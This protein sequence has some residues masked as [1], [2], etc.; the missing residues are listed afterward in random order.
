MS[1]KQRTFN[2]YLVWRRSMTERGVSGWTVTSYSLKARTDKQAQ[3]R[4]AKMF[5]SAGFHSMSLVAVIDGKNPNSI[6]Q[7]TNEN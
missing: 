1:T 4:L 2:N 6:N 3:S 5:K 7:N